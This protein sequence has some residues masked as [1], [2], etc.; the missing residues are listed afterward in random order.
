MLHPTQMLDTLVLDSLL[1]SAVVLN[2]TQVLRA[3]HMLHA[4]H[5]LGPHVASTEARVAAA[6]ATHVAPAHVPASHMAT[7]HVTTA[8]HMAAATTMSTS[9]VARKELRGANERKHQ[10]RSQHNAGETNHGQDSRLTTASV[11]PALVILSAG[12]ATRH[13]NSFDDFRSFNQANRDLLN[14]P[15]ATL[16]KWT[17]FQDE[18]AKSLQASWQRFPVGT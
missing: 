3:A 7:T 8:A 15:K 5:V 13:P 1:H 18:P 12:M 17:C 14:A 6:E 9:T 4:T 11:I 2:A 16:S 10:T